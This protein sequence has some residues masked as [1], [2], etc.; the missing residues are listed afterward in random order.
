MS[1]E[2]C[3][4]YFRG[5]VTFVHS[6][7]YSWF[8][9]DKKKNV[10]HYCLCLSPQERTRRMRLFNFKQQSVRQESYTSRII[11]FPEELPNQASWISVLGYFQFLV[12]AVRRERI[13]FTNRANVF[14][15]KSYFTM[16]DVILGQQWQPSIVLTG[17]GVSP[18]Q[19]ARFMGQ[20]RR[21][22]LGGEPFPTRW[23]WTKEVRH[24][25]LNS[26]AS[27]G[28]VLLDRDTSNCEW[29]WMFHK[30]EVFVSLNFVH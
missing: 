28:F 13:Q 23:S 26:G 25:A 12:P 16:L 14:S 3:I 8:W 22:V 27:T 11:Q 6:R 1:A 2:I 9:E 5:Y 10:F 4:F 30:Y 24:T 20:S 18:H 15:W 21:T 17:L 29:S 19:V 7:R